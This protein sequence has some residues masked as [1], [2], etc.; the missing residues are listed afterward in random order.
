MATTE[1]AQPGAQQTMERMLRL[2]VQKNGSDLYISAHAQ[3][4]LRLHGLCVPASS[5]RLGMQEP[6]DLL[7]ALIGEQAA[8]SVRPPQTLQRVVS[9]PDGGRLR[10]NVFFQRGTLAFSA[11]YL[12]ATLPSIGEA[13]LTPVLGTLAKANSGLVLIAGSAGAGKTTTA[14][15][16]L[17][18]R[19]TEISGHILVI[20]EHCE[21]LLQ[22]KKSLINQQQVGADIASW[23]SAYE[24]AQRCAPDVVFISELND[25][26]S[27]A[28]ALQLAQSGH[29]C[30]ATVNATSVPEAL[31]RFMQFFPDYERSTIGVQ[32]SSALHAVVVQKLLR[33]KA[34][35]RA[36]VC[37][38]L[39]NSEAIAGILLAGSMHELARLDLD[40]LAGGLSWG[41]D[42]ARLQAQGLAFEETAYAEPAA[43]NPPSW[44]HTTF[45]DFS[46]GARNAG[47][48]ASAAASPF[49]L[50]L[51][52]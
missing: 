41:Q 44:G 6:V 14:A 19:N 46:G 16:L 3:P 50:S 48:A 12:P 43:S 1:P 30:I 40:Q 7:A 47:S 49:S 13:Q 35:P 29:L 37:D 5:R 36:A 38:I 11:R 33:T 25:G 27:A 17:D 4:V 42:L 26:T 45:A 32:L 18:H 39:R 51:R 9:L 34:G 28:A 24:L 8:K 21:Y 52:P 20:E 31:Q 23:H 15:S 2:L 10:V 22:S